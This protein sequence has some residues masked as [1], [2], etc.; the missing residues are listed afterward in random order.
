MFSAGRVNS[1]LNQRRFSDSAAARH[2]GE[3]PTFSAD[4]L[5]QAAEFLSAAIKS[6]SHSGFR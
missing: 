6:P 4:D 1:S 2:L 5:G 3:V